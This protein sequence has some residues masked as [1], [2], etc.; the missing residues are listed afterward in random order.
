[1]MKN[2]LFHHIPTFRNS[3]FKK[4]NYS[5]Y[6]TIKEKKDLK[7][8]KRDFGLFK[9]LENFHKSI[10]NKTEPY[11]NINDAFYG[12]LL[13]NFLENLLLKKKE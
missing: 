13:L 8:L 7:I 6:L 4:F 9:V 10:K 12:A 11:V 2:L 5:Y 3:N 1:M